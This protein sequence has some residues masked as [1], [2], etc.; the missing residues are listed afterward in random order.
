MLSLAEKSQFRSKGLPD[1]S[2]EDLIKEDEKK[3]HDDADHETDDYYDEEE[4]SFE[5]EKPEEISTISPTSNPFDPS[6]LM[7][8]FMKDFDF[9]SKYEEFLPNLRYE[10][11]YLACKKKKGSILIPF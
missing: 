5:I 8:C 7:S 1:E 9:G 10:K 2:S 11:C 3:P 4:S 6:K